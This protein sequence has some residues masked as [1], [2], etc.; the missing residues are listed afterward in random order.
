LADHQGLFWYEIHFTIF[1]ALEREDFTS[2]E[3]QEIENLLVEY[4]RNERRSS[5]FAAWKAGDVLGDEWLSERT[6]QLLQDLV[7]AAV[8]SVGRIAALHGLAHALSTTNGAKRNAIEDA[9]RGVAGRDRSKAVRE[10]ADYYLR[11][12]GCGA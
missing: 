4:I 7:V 6:V 1:S 10:A 5:G 11:S 8:Y 12:A 2:A 3:Q 9:I